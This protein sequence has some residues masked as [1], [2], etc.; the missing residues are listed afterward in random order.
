[1]KELHATGRG[2]QFTSAPSLRNVR[3]SGSRVDREHREILTACQD[4]D[5]RRK[6]ANLTGAPS[7]WEL[8]RVLIRNVTF[9]EKRGPSRGLNV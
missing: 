3:K 8:D 9:L 5:G 6:F 4:Y 2:S 7:L 1:M